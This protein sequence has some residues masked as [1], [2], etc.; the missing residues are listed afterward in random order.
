MLGEQP[1]EREEVL[2]AI[3]ESLPIA[4]FD[5][6]SD[7]KALAPYWRLADLG[8]AARNDRTVVHPELRAWVADGR[9]ATELPLGLEPSWVGLDDWRARLRVVEEM[10][11]RLSERNDVLYLREREELAR[12]RR[13]PWVWELRLDMRA[14][15][16]GLREVCQ[17]L[18]EQLQDVG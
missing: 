4:L 10:I 6:A 2:A 11:G 5:A 3:L 7:L 1:A 13:V 8:L 9:R 18:R 17:L 16:G 15:L 12:G 14:A